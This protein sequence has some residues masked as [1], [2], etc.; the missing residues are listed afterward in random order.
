MDM[1]GVSFFYTML[2]KMK[3]LLS[4][5]LLLLLLQQITFAA[6]DSSTI[7]WKSNVIERLDGVV[8]YTKIK[9]AGTYERPTWGRDD[10]EVV[11]TLSKGGYEQD[12]SNIYFLD[13]KTG[14]VEALTNE[15]NRR[16]ETGNGTLWAEEGLYFTELRNGYSMLRLL[17]VSVEDMTEVYEISD[18]IPFPKWADVGN[19]SLSPDGQWMLYDS[20][21]AETRTDG[22]KVRQLYKMNKNTGEII[23]LTTGSNDK[24]RG[25]WSPEGSL[26]LYEVYDHQYREW[27]LYTVDFLGKHH[28]RFTHSLGDETYGSFSPD[29]QWVV[30]TASEEE[31]I[32]GASSD[33]N[34]LY[35]QSTYSNIPYQI[36]DSLF[37]DTMPTW[38]Q[39]GDRILF[40]TSTKEPVYGIPVWVGVIEVPDLEALVEEE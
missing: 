4:L 1:D 13:V 8:I 22:S 15:R 20:N 30:Y 7:I 6:S 25:R 14:T 17:K 21:S 24:R 34:K 27:S 36:T 10:S 37:Y 33:R 16:L 11:F 12:Y 3:K 39:N 29:G 31:E 23:Q 35:L 32:V 40:Q 5:G 38:S 19:P 28:R 2:Y 9:E 26:I 18:D